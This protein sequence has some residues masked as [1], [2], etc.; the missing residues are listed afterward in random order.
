MISRTD[1]PRF[2]R[3]IDV[4]LAISIL[5]HFLLGGFVFVHLPAVT[6]MMERLTKEPK[7]DEK[8]VAL[9]TTITIEKRTTPRAVPP[10]KPQPQRP[11]VRPQQQVQPQVARAPRPAVVPQQQPVP[12]PAPSELARIVPH[13][14][15]HVAPRK[16]E[17]VARIMA[18]RANPNPMLSQQQLAQ[19]QQAFAQTIA[20][21]RAANDPTRVSA[22]A[23]PST[24]KHAH[25]DIAGIND[26]MRHGEGILT[27]QK[28]YFANV[29]G[30]SKGI[31]YYVNY[32]I[33]FS[34]GA[35]DSGPVYWPICYQRKSD[36]F[37]NNWQHFPLP[38]PPPGWQPS[39]AEWAVIAQHPLLRLYFPGRFPDADDSGN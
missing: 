11:H 38:G 4:A 25:L 10:A 12:K 2:R 36:P 31:C 6:K 19:M 16:P 30:D 34:N 33:N 32:S 28:S 9:S 17:Q 7:K 5:L 1:E 35:F 21:A 14:K 37:W 22:S 29:D 15:E 13:A 27:P 8:M 23:A 18:P 20:A 3:T 39:A 24:M 26:L